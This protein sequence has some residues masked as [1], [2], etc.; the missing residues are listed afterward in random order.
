MGIVKYS[1]L[2]ISLGKNIPFVAYGW[3]PGQ[4][5]ITSSIIK[6]N[7]QMVK[8]MQKTIYEPLHKIAGNLIEPYFLSDEH[9]RG[10]YRFP[11]Y[12]HP[13]AFLDYDEEKIYE[14]ISR[15]GWEKPDNVDA[16][17]TN[18]LLNSF[19]NVVHKRRFNFHPYSFELASLVREGYIDRIDALNRLNLQENPDIVAQV[20]NR[21]AVTDDYTN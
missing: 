20:R 13:L 16:N 12:I 19:A 10:F 8:I 3:S 11:Y 21:L 7:P 5:P 9:F 18:C 4:A 17:S 14:N 2:R 15:L 1:T 6:T